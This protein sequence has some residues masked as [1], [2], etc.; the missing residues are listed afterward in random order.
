VAVKPACVNSVIVLFLSYS[1]GF[2]DFFI[3][4]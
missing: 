3:V 4:S 1:F 2:L